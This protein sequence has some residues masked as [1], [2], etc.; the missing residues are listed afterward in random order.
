L[1]AASPEITS[2]G[3]LGDERQA[4]L[5]HQGLEMIFD[6]STKCDLAS[7]IQPVEQ[8]LEVLQKSDRQHG[9]LTSRLSLG[10]RRKRVVETKWNGT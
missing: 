9:I 4:H 7:Q 2:T 6:C 3:G 5:Y 10:L 8:M 1:R